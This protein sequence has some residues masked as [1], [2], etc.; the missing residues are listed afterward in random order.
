VKI[1]HG[2]RTY[3]YVEDSFMYEGDIWSATSGKP[4]KSGCRRAGIERRELDKVKEDFEAPG[5][6][7]LDS[8]TAPLL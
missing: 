7:C 3:L 6:H 5:R 2:F 8:V 4:A 1:F